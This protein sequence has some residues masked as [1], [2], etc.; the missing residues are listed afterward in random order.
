MTAKKLLEEAKKILQED[1]ND[2]P[3][4]AMAVLAIAKFLANKGK[5]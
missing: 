5:D 2:D 1:F 4:K 3:Q